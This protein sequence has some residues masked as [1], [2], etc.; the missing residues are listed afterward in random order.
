LEVAAFPGR[1]DA[2]PRL[3]GAALEVARFAGAPFAG[4]ALEE[5]RA[6]PA[7]AAACFAG[8]LPVADARVVPAFAPAFCPDGAFAADARFDTAP[9]PRDGALAFEPPAPPERAPA[10][11]E[12]AAFDV[13]EA[14]A[15]RPEPFAAPAVLAG[16]A[17]AIRM[18]SRP[19]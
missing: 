6:L 10:D 18:S 2:T 14:P 4:V 12:V 11:L 15:P 13:P 5:G 9:A 17:F 1:F 19:A 7:L 8:A 16:A 3:A